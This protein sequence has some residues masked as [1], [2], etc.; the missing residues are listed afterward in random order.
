MTRITNELA[1]ATDEQL[2]S[3]HHLESK[4][5]E[6]RELCTELEVLRAEKQMLNER[7]QMLMEQLHKASVKSGVTVHQMCLEVHR[8]KATTMLACHQRTVIV[9]PPFAARH[10][11]R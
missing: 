8:L 5:G 9:Q 4:E 1:H 11:I 3:A 7:V 2:A 6:L 10:L